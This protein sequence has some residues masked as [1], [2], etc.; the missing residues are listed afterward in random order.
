MWFVK[1]FFVLLGF[2]VLLWFLVPNMQEQVQLQFWWPVKGEHEMPLGVALFL[3][4]FVGLVTFYVISIF[5]DLKVRT[6]VHRLRRENRRLQEELERMRRAPLEDI[7]SPT[8]SGPE[9]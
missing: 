1:A 2:L 3:A 7:E 4:F 8:E 6:Q 9:A 5:R